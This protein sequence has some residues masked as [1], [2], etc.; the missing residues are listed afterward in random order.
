MDNSGE[1]ASLP[2]I[3]TVNVRPVFERSL[4]TRTKTTI[5]EQAFCNK[6]DQNRISD[7]GVA[8]SNL[9]NREI[10]WQIPG[11]DNLDTIVEDENPDWG[12]DQ[13]IP[14]YKSIDQEFFKYSSRYFWNSRGVDSSSG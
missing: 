5:G 11:T 8:F 3:D 12:T 14:M 9:L 7:I 6:G 2:I 10:I 4:N 1:Q 13:I